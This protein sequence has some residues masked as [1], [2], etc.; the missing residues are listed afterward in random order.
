[1]LLY[2]FWGVFFP[3]RLSSDPNS[4]A[5]CLV[6]SWLSFSSNP[7]SLCEIFLQEV[8]SFQRSSLPGAEC[9]LQ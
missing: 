3:Q 6:G 1:M 5:H 7:P 9:E 4:F 8:L 2:F